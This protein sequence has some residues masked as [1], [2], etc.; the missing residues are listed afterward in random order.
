MIHDWE[1]IAGR[2]GTRGRYEYAVCTRCGTIRHTHWDVADDGS[3]GE[4]TD[5]YRAPGETWQATDSGCGI[6]LL[7]RSTTSRAAR[8]APNRS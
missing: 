4:R 7:S 5:E 3:D 1:T 6:V 2:V 8:D